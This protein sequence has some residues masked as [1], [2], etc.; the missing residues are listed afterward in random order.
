VAETPSANAGGLGSMLGK[1]I[2]SHMLQL[3]TWCNQ[4]NIKKKKKV[5]RSLPEKKIKRRFRKQ[6]QQVQRRRAVKGL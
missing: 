1:G 5:N 4:I 2:K 6:E 3:K